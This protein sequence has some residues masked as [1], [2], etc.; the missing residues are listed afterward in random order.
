MLGLAVYVASN[1]TLIRIMSSLYMP[2]PIVFIGS[3]KIS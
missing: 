2:E 3:A 1:T